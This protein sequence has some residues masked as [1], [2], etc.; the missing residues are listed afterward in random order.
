MA[1]MRAFYEAF[2]SA[3]QQDP[4]TFESFE[5]R[6]MRYDVLWSLFENT[7]YRDVHSWSKKLKSDYGLYKYIRNIYNPA[8]RLGIFWQTHLLGGS[9]DLDAGDGR[10][11][12]S[13]LPI[14]TEAAP[15]RPAI[16][17]VWRWSNWATRKD[18]LSLWGS[19]LGDVGLRVI[20][21]PVRQTV[22]LDVVHPGTISEVTLDNAGNVKGYVIEKVVADPLGKKSS[23]IYSEIAERDG[24]DV[25]YTTLRDGTEYAWMG[26]AASWREPYGFIP[27]VLIKH[28]DV[29]LDW[30]WAEIYPVFSKVRELDDQ[31]SKLS[32]QVRKM[33]DAPWLFAGVD[34]PKKQVKTAG[35]TP[36]TD[37][38]EP[39][40]E[41]VPAIYGPTGATA[42]PLV[43]NLDIAA[44]GENIDRMLAEVER[45]L[46]EL[47]HDIWSAG[48]DASG[49]A[50]RISRQRVESKVRVRRQNYYDGIRRALQMALS[51][52]GMRNYDGFGGFGID[53]FKA[54]QLEFTI[55]QPPVFESD[56]LDTSEIDMAFWTA[57]KA[58]E[59]AGIPIE[60]YL[61]QKGWNQQDIARVTASEMYQQ[62]ITAGTFG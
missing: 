57:A 61:E 33:V 50:L 44:V 39:G 31:A 20:D 53:S 58:A 21:D 43:A 30:G 4:T 56:P 55:G 3:N 42:T 38:P 29:G 37:R 27:L 1:G 41:E 40:R 9:L 15:L 5:A 62:K 17:Q 7:A 51:I 8:N 54:G 13:V 32:D 22:S 11:A 46:P 45:D 36:T 6:Q 49:R 35:A 19:T 47:Q 23:V 12:P 10:S 59:E 34:G 26:E 16:G 18:I 28:F 60:L 25:V 52:G 24:D 48:S 14:L 2:M